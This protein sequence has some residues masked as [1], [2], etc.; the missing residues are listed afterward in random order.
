MQWH[1]ELPEQCP[2]QEAVLPSNMIIYRAV[3]TL[4]PTEDDFESQRVMYPKQLFNVDECRARSLSVSTEPTP[5][6]H[7]IRIPNRPERFVAKIRLTEESGL[8]L[9]TGKRTH[10][11]WW[12][13]RDFDPIAATELPEDSV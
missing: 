5:C 9:K 4:P 1:D 12:R 10:F 11:S 2:P 7:L 8:I 13:A 6:E 3:R